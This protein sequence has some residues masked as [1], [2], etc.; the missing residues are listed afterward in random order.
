MGEFAVNVAVAYR[1]GAARRDYSI[2]SAM[3]IRDAE[4]FITFGNSINNLI[5]RH[6][7]DLEAA[8]RIA[9]RISA[10]WLEA[11]STSAGPKTRWVDG[12]PEY[13]FYI[14]ALRKLFPD[15]LFVHVFRDVTAVVQSMLNFHRVAG[16]HLVPNQQEAFEYWLR[17]VKAC[18]KAEQAYGPRVIYRLPYAKLIRSPEV[19]IRSLLD[20]IGEPFCSK[21]L[22]PLDERINSSDVPGDFKIGEDTTDAL[23]IEQA[24]QLAIE[25]ERV[26]QPSETSSAAAAEL[27]AL[28]EKQVEHVA[29]LDTR[30]HDAL[31]DVTALQNECARLHAELE[32][33]R[34]AYQAPAETLSNKD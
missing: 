31:R 5:L 21:C 26:P 3:E 13:S 2:L 19:A 20:F 30:Y 27:E 22:E 34:E 11:A 16:T 28:F 15:A 17:T 6:R 33:M 1:T 25:L 23:V 10:G 4:L 12:T 29:S 7:K 32:Q 8:R 14:C 18:V 9:S 24:R